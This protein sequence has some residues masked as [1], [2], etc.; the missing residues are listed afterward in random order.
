MALVRF[1]SAKV[2][3]GGYQPDLESLMYYVPMFSLGPY[4][5][6]R[7]PLGF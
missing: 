5:K 1:G 6:M 2:Y 7:Y 3:S 4:Q